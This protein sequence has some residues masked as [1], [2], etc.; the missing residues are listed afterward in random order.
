MSIQY[1][2]YLKKK[3]AKNKNTAIQHEYL[4]KK[5]ERKKSL[6]QK[7]VPAT[8]EQRKSPLTPSRSWR[9]RVHVIREGRFLWGDDI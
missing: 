5:R 1:I 2:T 8:T 7:L 6:Q 4:F 3:N 9:W